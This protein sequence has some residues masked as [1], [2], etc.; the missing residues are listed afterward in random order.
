MSLVRREPDPAM[1]LAGIVSLASAAVAAVALVPLMAMFGAFALGATSVGQ[2]FGRL[3]DGLILIAYVLAAP[4]V[5]ATSRILKS[6]HP[7]FAAVG[8]LVGLAAIVAIAVLQW[9][10]ISGF[11][12]FEAQIGPVSVAF[13]VLGGWFMLSGYLGA[14]TLPYGVWIGALAALYIGYPILAYRLGRSLIAITGD[15]R[16]VSV[17]KVRPQA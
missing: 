16:H 7:V 14:G 13:L 12:T 2:T 5:L 11:L 10:L 15:G 9:Q 17:P 8:S 1:R 4:G 3:N 6:R